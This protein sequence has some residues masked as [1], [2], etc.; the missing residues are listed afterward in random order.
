[1][2]HTSAVTLTHTT[3]LHP[4]V[5]AEFRQGSDELIAHELAHQWFGNLV[6]CKDWA[7]IW[8]NEGFAMQ[9][10]WLWEE[11]HYGRDDADYSVWQQR[12]HWLGAQRLYAIPIVAREYGELFQLAGNFYGK[13][14][15]VL[16]M[17]RLELGDADYFRGV[18]H[19]LEKHRG[20]NVVAAD[21]AAAFEEATGRNL[22]F[23]FDQWIYGAGAP[24]F[25]VSYAYDEG[26]RQVKLDVKQTQKVEG[27][28]RL[29]HVPVEVQITTPSGKRDFPIHISKASETFAFPADERPLLVLF[30]KGNR[31]LKSLSF[32][33]DWREW[34]YQLRHAE[35]VAGRAD[36]ARALGEIRDNAEVVAALGEAARRDRFWGI[37]VQA[38]RALKS[39]GGAEAQKQ[40]VAALANAEPWVRMVAVEQMGTFKDD[41]ETG[42][43]LEKIFRE[44]KSFRVRSAA[45]VALGQQRAANAFGV[46]S[47]AVRVESP[48]DRIR[49]AALRGLGALGDERALATLL[50]WAAPGK[51]FGVRSAAIGGL[52][53]LAKG[54]KELTAK[55]LAFA[56]E[57]YQS[58]RF[59]AL[60]ALGQRNDPDVA[61]ALEAMLQEGE[62]DGFAAQFARDIIERLKKQGESKPSS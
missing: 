26:A 33:K 3:L 42:E 40:M 6:T 13:A 21:V 25:E 18:R 54:D 27:A 17:L 31:I 5:A 46:L 29:F 59:P 7:S 16:H 56:R 4:Q 57:P 55:L 58:V 11:H 12:N 41:P 1:M 15:L 44:D 60:V 62:F 19:F 10:S 23:F 45:L 35:S 36:A 30:D 50:E 48:D 49:A 2:E 28:V 22:D 8:V 34:V 43:R 39:I 51:P 24:R 52:G 53:Q 14:A 20:R 38:I 37:R 32:Q 61:A 47:A 9:F